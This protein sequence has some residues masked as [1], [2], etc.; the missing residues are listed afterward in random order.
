MSIAFFFSFLETPRKTHVKT[1][2]NTTPRKITFSFVKHHVTPHLA[3]F[4]QV[5][6]IH[7]ANVQE[8]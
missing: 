4:P 1:P 2:R 8:T 3:L 6:C 7:H 5:Y